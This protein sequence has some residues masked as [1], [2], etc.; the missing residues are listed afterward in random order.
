MGNRKVNQDFEFVLTLDDDIVCQRYFSVNKY[1][2][3]GKNSFEF[4]NTC[5]SAVQII[6]NQIKEYSLNDMNK[7]QNFYDENPDGYDTNG[8]FE[9]YYFYIK[10]RDT[11]LYARAFPAYVFPNKVRRNVDIRKIIPEL[12]SSIQKVL[13][14]TDN[15]LDFEPCCYF[16]NPV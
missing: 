14:S 10:K 16:S 3:K 5:D 1:N 13:S 8:Q 12:I 7:F 2:P 6:H 9:Y 4:K 11:T 15:E